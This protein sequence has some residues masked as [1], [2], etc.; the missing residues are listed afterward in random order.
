MLFW[1]DLLDASGNENFGVHWYTVTLSLT[2]V[3]GDGLVDE[4]EYVTVCHHFGVDEKEAKQA[5]AKLNMKE[6]NE[7]VFRECYCS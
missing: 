7:L 4:N 1:F 2:N 5:F 6:V 3:T